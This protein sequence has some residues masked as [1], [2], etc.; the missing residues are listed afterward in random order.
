MLRWQLDVTWQEARAH[1]GLES[2]RQWQA[3]A[4]ARTTPTLWALF[5]MVTLGAGRLAQDHALPVRQAVW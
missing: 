2:Q 5:S 1:V 3:W 4:M